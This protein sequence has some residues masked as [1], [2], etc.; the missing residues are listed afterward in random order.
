MFVPS[1]WTWLY[2][3]ITPLQEKKTQSQTLVL[4]HNNMNTVWRCS[5][6]IQRQPD[7]VDENQCFDSTLTKQRLV[8]QSIILSSVVW[9]SEWQLSDAPH[10]ILTESR[11]CLTSSDSF[12]YSSGSLQIPILVWISTHVFNLHA[13]SSFCLN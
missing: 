8:Q 12:I 13:F 1:T 4:F 10:N 3:F 7:L 6:Q 11:A 2:D 5:L 9:H